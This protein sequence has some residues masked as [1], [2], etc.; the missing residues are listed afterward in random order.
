[1]VCDAAVVMSA[2]RQLGTGR[3]LYGSDE[4]CNLLR[5]VTYRH[6]EL[7]QRVSSDF[8]Y[9]WLREDLRLSH[10]Y[11]GKGAWLIHFQSMKAIF[12][13]IDAVA[14]PAGAALSQ[15]IFHDNA[16][17]FLPAGA[18]PMAP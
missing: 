11:L 7:G 6:P 10:G 15:A 16:A 12:E 2:I 9:H 5:Y 14:G 1:M 18:D 3:V 13:A 4:P 8:P 17:G